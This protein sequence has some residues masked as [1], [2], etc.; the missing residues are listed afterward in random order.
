[1][2]SVFGKPEKNVKLQSFKI[3]TV[4]VQNLKS[5]NIL[6][7]PAEKITANQCVYARNKHR[8]IAKRIKT[9]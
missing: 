1:M 9:S 7:L 4:Q 2:R 6:H 8:A 3:F 5:V